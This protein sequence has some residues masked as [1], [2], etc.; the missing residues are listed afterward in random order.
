[1]HIRAAHSHTLRVLEHAHRLVCGLR[2]ACAR[3][4]AAKR[5]SAALSHDLRALVHPRRHVEARLQIV[6]AASAQRVVHV[7]VAAVHSSEPV[8]GAV[9]KVQC[10]VEG[11]QVGDFAKGVAGGRRRREGE[12]RRRRALQSRYKRISKA[13]TGM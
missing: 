13:Y 7:A 4:T 10:A 5:K 8:V 1:M 2:S 9:V 11:G 6:T 3:K 12:H